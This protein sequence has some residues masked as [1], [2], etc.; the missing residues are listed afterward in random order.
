MFIYLV[1]LINYMIVWKKSKVLAT[2]FF[3]SFSHVIKVNTCSSSYICKSTLLCNNTFNTMLS[4]RNVVMCGKDCIVV[5]IA[6]T[7]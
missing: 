7:G 1:I 2:P 5:V 4:K 6:T 3:F